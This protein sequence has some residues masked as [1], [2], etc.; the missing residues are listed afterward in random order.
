[1]TMFNSPEVIERIALNHV[2]Q[3]RREARVHDQLRLARGDAGPGRFARLAT[4]LAALLG[5]ALRRVATGAGAGSD[6]ACEVAC[7]ER[8]AGTCRCAQLGHAP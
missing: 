1:M 6:G 4:L 7:P 8:L 3:R 5:G 2:E